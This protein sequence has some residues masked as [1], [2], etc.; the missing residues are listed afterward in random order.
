[1][2]TGGHSKALPLLAQLP[3]GD[4]GESVSG[5]RRQKL[6]SRAIRNDKSCRVLYTA[7]YCQ[8]VVIALGPKEESVTE[9]HKLDRFFRVILAPAGTG[10]SI[11]NIGVPMS[12]TPKP[13][14]RIRDGIAIPTAC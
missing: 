4:A 10:H 3:D 2:T 11:T 12:T 14:L 6:A 9:V 8:S 5:M 13:R 1:M 7:K